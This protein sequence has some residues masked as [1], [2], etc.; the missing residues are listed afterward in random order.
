MAAV[1]QPFAEAAFAFGEVI[2]VN[3]RRVLIKP[4]RDHVLGVFDG[5][6]DNVVD[7]FTLGVVAVAM[8]TAGQFGVV[9]VVLDDRATVAEGAD[10]D[11]GRQFGHDFVRCRRI[12]V[13]FAHHDP[14]HIFEHRRAILIDAA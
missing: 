6:A 7:F 14:A 9:E 11:A 12:L 10:I 1:N 4:R 5:N 3:A 2:E 8:R 13:A